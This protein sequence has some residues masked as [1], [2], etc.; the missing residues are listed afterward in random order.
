MASLHDQ[1]QIGR[2][3]ASIASPRGLF[4]GVGSRHVVGELSGPLEHFTLIVWTICVLDLLGHRS[5]LIHG[6]R[7]ANKVTP[8]NAVQRVA[9]GAYFTIYLIP[10]TNATGESKHHEI[11]DNDGTS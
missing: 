5:S 7:D 2:E 10:A 9:S 8:S 3:G 1:A 6:V 11:S 4:V